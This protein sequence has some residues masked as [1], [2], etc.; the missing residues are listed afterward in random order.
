MNG[1]YVSESAGGCE[2]CRRWLAADES[3]RDAAAST[4]F[5]FSGQHLECAAAHEL[6]VVDIDDE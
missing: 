5:C 3:Q 6:K 2:T 4:P 1:Q